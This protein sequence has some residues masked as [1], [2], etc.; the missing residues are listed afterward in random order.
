MDDLDGEERCVLTGLFSHTTEEE[1]CDDDVWDTSQ[2]ACFLLVGG[3]PNINRKIV[4][5]VGG[6]FRFRNFKF[7]FYGVVFSTCSVINVAASN[8]QA[9][10]LTVN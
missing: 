5:D 9:N 6:A 10:K 1:R 3:F 4:V 7:E 8:N 2:I